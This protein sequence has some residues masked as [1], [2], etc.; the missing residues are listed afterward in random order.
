MLTILTS[1]GCINLPEERT[2][3]KGIAG[4]PVMTHN[5]QIGAMKKRGQRRAAYKWQTTHTLL[6]GVGVC[7]VLC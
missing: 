3:R 2:K 1:C 5:C 6:N 4:M 7:V